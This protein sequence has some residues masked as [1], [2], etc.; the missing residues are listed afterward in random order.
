M[1]PTSG[2]PLLMIILTARAAAWTFP[3]RQI[4]LACKSAV[5]LRPILCC[6]DNDQQNMGLTELQPNYKTT[7]DSRATSEM[8]ATDYVVFVGYIGMFMVFFYAVAAAMS[9]VR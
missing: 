8:T 9:L 7:E 2:M 1:A 5:T 4:S 3:S 6:A